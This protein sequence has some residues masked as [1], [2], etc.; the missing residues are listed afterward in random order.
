MNVAIEVGPGQGNHDGPLWIM[1]PKSRYCPVATSCVERD[2]RIARL[3]VKVLTDRHS[4]PQPPQHAGPA[5]GRYS[6]T[7]S[8]VGRSGTRHENPHVEII[9]AMPVQ[10]E[11]V[12][13]RPTS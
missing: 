12:T 8:G 9:D 5:D 2:E 11:H 13:Q 4:M 10:R 3:A 7:L 6:I 1:P